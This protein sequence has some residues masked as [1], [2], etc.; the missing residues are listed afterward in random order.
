MTSPLTA[1]ELAQRMATGQTSD[2]VEAG[3]LLPYAALLIQM[4][5]ALECS[6]YALKH[7]NGLRNGGF[8]EAL[9][10]KRNKPDVTGTTAAQ[11]AKANDEIEAAVLRG[12]D[13][14]RAALSTSDALLARE[15]E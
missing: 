9:S 11:Y 12:K 10:P 15:V 3:P 8:N 4:R 5:E 7:A 2:Y 14:V 13:A 6:H 1:E